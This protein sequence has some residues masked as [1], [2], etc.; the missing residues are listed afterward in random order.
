MN[1]DQAI[2]EMQR[3]LDQALAEDRYFSTVEQARFDELKTLAASATE[4][5]AMETEV[6]EQPTHP[7][8]ALGAPAVHTRQRATAAGLLRGA[9]ALA[10]GERGVDTG[11]ASEFDKAVR[12]RFPHRKFEGAVAF[13]AKALLVA[14][15]IG[16]LGGGL[17]AATTGDQFLDSL[18]F[19]VDDAIA[20][21]RLAAALGV[22]TILGT[23]DRVH[24]T[25]LTGR[26][27]PA[28][29]ARDG[30]VGD[31]DA[32]FDAIEVEPKTIGTNVLVKRSAL[33]YS[34]HPQVEP[35]LLGDLREAMLDALDHAVLYGAGG[36][37]PTGIVGVAT[38]GHT[39]S[40]LADAYI[41]RNA[42]LAYQKSDDGFRWLLPDLCQ[43]RLATTAA[44]SGATTPAVSDGFLANYP[45]ILNPLTA[46]GSPTVSQQ[47]YMAGN[48]SFV[49]LVLFD[50]VSLMANPY[51]A[52]YKSGSIELRVMADAN[53]LVRD[54]KRVFVGEANI[55]AV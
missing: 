40:T 21:P 49:H 11:M 50:S 30:D 38:P 48:F 13:S 31:S 39:L 8:R 37:E 28:W 47:Q 29:I 45:Y 7:T 2:E 4:E 53:V 18:F 51:G 42:L 44:F 1:K 24:I 22:N 9:I 34:S 41:V 55:L 54:E 12:A 33:L 20:G 26:V 10:C 16:A 15:D 23:E 46:G 17:A 3:L 52:G 36:L 35:F 6:I 32:S 43:A 19:R 5:P 25:K 27:R 14:K